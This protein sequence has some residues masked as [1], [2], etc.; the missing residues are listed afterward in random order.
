MLTLKESLMS[1]CGADFSQTLKVK[2][3]RQLQF[4]RNLAKN[5]NLKGEKKA[6]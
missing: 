6:C 5:A 2:R 3:G 4:E 1:S